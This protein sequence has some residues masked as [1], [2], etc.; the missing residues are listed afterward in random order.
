[1]EKLETDY[2][3]E[4]VQQVM[5]N[6]LS[7]AIK[8]TPSGGAVQVKLS[9]RDEES[10][11]VGAAGSSLI[12]HPSYLFI[13]VSDTGKGIPEADLPHIFDRFYQVDGSTTRAGEGTGIGLA[14]TLELV[15]LMGGEI[16]VESE[17]GIG[18]V[19][20]VRLPV[21]HEAE[22]LNIRGFEDL[23]NTVLA[24]SNPQTLESPNPQILLIEDNPDVVTYL[25]AILSGSY[26]LD[27]AY[28][29]RIGIEKALEAI[30]D[31]I[32]S[33][34]MMPEKDGFQVLDALKNDERTSHIPIVLLTAKADVAS[35]VIGLRR[36]ADAYLPK[37]FDK[38]ELLATLEMMMENRRRLVAHFA[39]G[40]G[41]PI[42][43][44]AEITPAADLVV[45][46][47]FLQK[48]RQVVAENYSDDGFAL[49]QLCEAIGMSRSQLFRKMKALTDVSPSDFIRD[50]RMQQAKL[51]LEA[52]QHNVKE[53]AFKVGFKDI[54]HFSRTYQ[55]TFGSR[56]APPISS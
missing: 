24:S 1:L 33:D 20:T 40:I 30:P 35:K 49:P 28:N 5:S 46:D 42:A 26:N 50:Y 36:G 47:A 32:I 2:D 45:E 7:N 56:R 23:K 37:P 14:H 11:M 18:T 12:P 17:V 15:K 3:P 55:E 48:I 9:M 43:Q 53:V 54:S 22:D 39:T 27:I 41:Q 51:L 31:L 13:S 38:A 16:S 34:V 21:A 4:Q 8:F 10:G 44:A 6:L 29:G 52:A 19:F 25:K